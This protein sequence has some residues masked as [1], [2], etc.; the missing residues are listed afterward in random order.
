[1]GKAL[2]ATAEILEVGSDEAKRRA[3]AKFI[4]RVAKEDGSLDAV[5][6]R[7]R[8]VAAL[9]RMQDGRVEIWLAPNVLAKLKMLRRASE[10]YSDV[11]LA[12]TG[13]HARR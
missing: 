9:E 4:I 5:A 1:M 12:L 6:L 2:E 10:S 11:I 8:A 7:D 13:V 3:I